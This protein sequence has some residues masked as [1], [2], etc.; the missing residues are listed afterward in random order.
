MDSWALRRMAAI[1]MVPLFRSGVAE[2]GVLPGR[3]AKRAALR[4]P[5]RLYLSS[6]TTR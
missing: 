2:G 3:G 4:Y 5:R 6:R 1:L